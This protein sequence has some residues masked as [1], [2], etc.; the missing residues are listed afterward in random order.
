MTE[1]QAERFSDR[2]VKLLETIRLSLVKVQA[3]IRKLSETLEQLL[4]EFK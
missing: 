2:H 4:K 3:E 1:N